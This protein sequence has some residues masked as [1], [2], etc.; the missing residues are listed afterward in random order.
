M[1]TLYSELSASLSVF[2]Q[3]TGV[4]L[5]V[6]N[7][8][9]EVRE[10]FGQTCE[11]CELIHQES[12]MEQKCRQV[13]KD[14]GLRSRELGD[15]YFFV[16]HGNMVHI[17]IALMDRDRYA[18]SVLAGPM[19]MEYP[20]A[21]TLDAVIK[22]CNIPAGCRSI[23]FSAMRDVLL[24]EPRRVYYI[25]ELLFRLI[26]NLL[27]ED[28]AK[29]L[30]RHRQKHS[31]Q[32]MIGES[33]QNM[34]TA[35]NMRNIQEKQETELVE[36]IEAGD[37][38]QVQVILNDILGGIYFSSGN[39]LQ[40]IKIRTNEL[41]SV[42]Y[43]RLLQKGIDSNEMYE[44]VSEFQK[45]SARSSDVTEISYELGLVLRKF[46]EIMHDGIHQ[47]ASDLV[48]KSLDYIH[49]NYRE[50]ITLED[51]AEHVAVSPAH[52]SRLFKEDMGIGFAA[53][54]N[55]IR[56]KKAKELLQ[57][58]DRSLVDIALSVGY[59]NQQYFSM[60]FK[61]EYGISPGQYRRQVNNI[62]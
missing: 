40:L 57:E 56:M 8:Y 53:Y 10:S 30:D 37:I 31:Q 41:V 20:D 39:D 26:Y 5:S 16:C 55:K 25:G 24:V 59:S 15:C 47:E 14:A 19:L 54:V 27:S 45:N 21:A 36:L 42:I 12:E 44:M 32:E 4:S 1:G 13:H 29:M 49:K 46:V 35:D 3:A 51:T 28:S 61:R 58:S 23:F 11:Y 18:G 38:E 50:R 9:G 34:K 17:A 22:Q 2:W 6:L 48:C 33:L 52:L 7:E 43:R 60:V 62:L